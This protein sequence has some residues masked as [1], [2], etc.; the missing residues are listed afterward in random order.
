MFQLE[1]LWDGRKWVSTSLPDV[2]IWP[3]NQFKEK[4]PKNETSVI[5]CLP[6]SCCKTV[7]CHFF[8]LLN[9]KKDIG[10]QQFWGTID[11]HSREQTTMVVNS[12]PDISTCVFK[13]TNEC[14]LK[15]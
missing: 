4:V 14:G 6:S 7:C 3:Q 1:M 11:K 10:K 12:V 8:A 2:I 15:I 13:R 9:T 5:I